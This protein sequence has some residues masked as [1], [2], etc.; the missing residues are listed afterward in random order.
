MLGRGTR[1]SPDL[2]PPKDR[3]V[4]VDCFDGTLVEAFR[5]RSRFQEGPPRKPTLTYEQIINAI[6][7]NEDV[8]YN[9][10]RL[11]QRFHGIDKRTT[12]KAR[13]EFAVYVP[14]GDMK[15]FGDSLAQRLDEDRSGLLAILQDSDFV[16]LLYG[17]ERT[18]RTFWKAI[19]YE[20]EVSST[21]FIRERNKTYSFPDYIEEF[22]AFVRENRQTVDAIAVLLDRPSDMNTEVL[23]SLRKALAAQPQVFTE[24]NLRRAYQAELADIISMLKHAADDEQ[25]LLSAEERVDRAIEQLRAGRSFTDEQERWLF[26]IREHLVKNLVMEREDFD[27]FPIFSN[28]GGGGKV[29][30]AFGEALDDLLRDLNEKVAS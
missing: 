20:D 21:S 11:R 2:F 12:V 9:L 30:K 29:Q 4:L 26:R 16:K 25:P 15:A 19:D 13:K 1:K 18:K 22:Q 17:F 8:G 24:T 3:F 6:A 5:K 7:N 10:K 23:S 14:D 28:A 27:V